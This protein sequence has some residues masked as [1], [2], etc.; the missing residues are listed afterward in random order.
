MASEPQAHIVNR[1]PKLLTK[2][3]LRRV[4]GDP[5][6]HGVLIHALDVWRE[7]KIRLLAGNSRSNDQDTSRR[8]KP[9]QSFDDR[10]SDAIHFLRQHDIV[11][12]IMRWTRVWFLHQA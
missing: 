10:L 11:H 6:Q 1:L 2:P 4:L 8:C 7:A 9:M 3:L 12:G 5:R